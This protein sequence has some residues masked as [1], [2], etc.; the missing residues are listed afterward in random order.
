MK[1]GHG[2]RKG[3]SFERWL[4]VQL[5]LWVSQGKRRDCFWRTA[6]SGG[7]ATIAK[8][9]GVDLAHQAGDIGA[10]HPLGHALTSHFFPEGKHYK[11]LQIDNFLLK[12]KG[13]LWKF[14]LKASKEAKK[15]NK[16]PMLIARQNNKPTLLIVRKGTL[17]DVCPAIPV[18]VVCKGFIEVYLF[19]DVMKTTFQRPK[20]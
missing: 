20:R 17:L 15:H 13:P 10:I 6:L 3:G 14:W 12:Q 9:M 1:K 8:R 18:L 11:N 4:A 5:S 2:N 16:E 7:R 19:D